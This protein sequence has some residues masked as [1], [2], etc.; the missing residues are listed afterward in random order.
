MLADRRRARHM[1]AMPVRSPCVNV[2]EID[3]RTGWCRGCAR[4]LDE[5][6]A[7][8]LAD[9]AARLAITAALPGRHERLA[10]RRRWLGLI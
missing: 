7:W 9:E 10:R 2:C 6:A 4:T 5:I 8:P 3:R 1:A